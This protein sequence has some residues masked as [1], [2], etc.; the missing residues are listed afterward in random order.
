MIP[1]FAGSSLMRA[2]LAEKRLGGIELLAQHLKLKNSLERL[3]G[4]FRCDCGKSS[5]L[6]TTTK[7]EARNLLQH[8]DIHVR[9]W[10]LLQYV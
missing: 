6:A 3:F 10:K 2:S 9:K 4:D 5:A 8:A 1:G 7:S